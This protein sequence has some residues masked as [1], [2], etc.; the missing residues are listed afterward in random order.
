MR[1]L[2]EH[3]VNPANDKLTIS[4]T[5]L[6]GAGGANHRYEIGGFST[7]NNPSHDDTREGELVILFQN[8]PINDAGVNGVTQ[9]VLLAIVADRLRSFQAGQFACRE[10]ALALTKIEEAQHWLHS[11]TLARMQRGVEGT[12]QQ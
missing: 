4:V 5:D 10:N 12:H 7:E 11:R 3:R 8:G 6:A 9:E 2:T 1:T